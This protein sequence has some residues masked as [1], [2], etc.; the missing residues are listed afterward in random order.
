VVTTDV[1]AL[2]EVV[3]TAADLVP[4][5]DASALADALTRVLA[6]DD[7]QRQ[8]RVDRGRRLAAARSWDDV[9][10]DVLAVVTAAVAERRTIPG[11]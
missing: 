7:D 8:A 10:G 5:G 11:P 4:V 9:A 1:G 3:G 6:L 2:R